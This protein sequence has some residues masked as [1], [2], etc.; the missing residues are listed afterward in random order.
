[1]RHSNII[2]AAVLATTAFGCNDEGGDSPQSTC[3]EKGMECTGDQ[4]CGDEEC[5]QAFD[6]PYMLHVNPYKTGSGVCQS[7]PISPVTVSF[8]A[9][10]IMTTVDAQEAELENVTAGASLIVNFASE[11]CSVELTAERLRTGHVKCNSSDMAVSMRLDPM[12][13]ESMPR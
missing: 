3:E 12:P 5:E 6:R 9:D 7:C 4:V 11:Q 8:N 10:W 2:L 13:F 1:M